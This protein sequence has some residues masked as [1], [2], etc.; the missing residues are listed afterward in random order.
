M[1]EGLTYDEALREAQKLEYAEA[2]PTLDV[3]SWDAAIKA[4][5]LA[6]VIM[7]SSI[8]IKDVER[9]YHQDHRGDYKEG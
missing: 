2:D 9:G 6:N 7:G 3:E 1:E 8:T 5:I 4:V